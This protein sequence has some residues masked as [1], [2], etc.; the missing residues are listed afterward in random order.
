MLRSLFANSANSAKRARATNY[1]EPGAHVQ[2]YDPT[3]RSWV[4]GEVVAVKSGS[5]EEENQ[6]KFSIAPRDETVKERVVI[7]EIAMIRKPEVQLMVEVDGLDAN[8]SNSGG[9]GGGGSSSSGSGSSSS[10]SSSSTA[11]GP[12]IVDCP[13]TALVAVAPPPTHVAIAGMVSSAL[14]AMAQDGNEHRSRVIFD[15]MVRDINEKLRHAAGK[16]EDAVIMD[17]VM[18]P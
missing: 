14:C 16:G 15:E 9:G 17:D 4:D 6:R 13:D 12:V 7:K 18:D 1:F 8:N 10:S 11:A 3:S 5:Q 2:F